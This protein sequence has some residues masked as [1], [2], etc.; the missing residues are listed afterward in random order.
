MPTSSEVQNTLKSI[1]AL[2]HQIENASDPAQ[3]SVAKELMQLLMELHGAGLERILEIVKQSV[4]SG[5][6]IT[7]ALGR[8]DLVRSLLLLYGLHPDG[9]ETRVAQALEKMRPYLK[10]HGGSAA[11]VRVEDS[12]VVTL[13]LEGSG[14]NSCHS[15]SAKLKLAVEEA[16]Y[17]AAPDVTAIIVHGLIEEQSPSIAFVPL[18]QLSGNGRQSNSDLDTTG[19]REAP[20]AQRTAI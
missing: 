1:E 2:V 17:D 11:L 6:S 10:S 18:A 19:L 20:K 3:A 13:R 9:I 4:P 12:G 8:D 16:I 5:A 14:C 15:S 7:D